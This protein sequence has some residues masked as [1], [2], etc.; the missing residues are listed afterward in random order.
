MP[1]ATPV[2]SAAS[3]SR[4]VRSTSYASTS[5]TAA[6]TLTEI[7]GLPDGI[8]ANPPAIDAVRSIA[9]GYDSANGVL[10]AFDI[11]ADGTSPPRWRREQHHACHPILYPDTGELVTND[12]D[13]DRMMDQIVVLD[14]ETGDERARVDTGSPLQ[15]VVF[16]A[17]GFGRDLYYV[18]FP[19]VSHISVR[20]DRRPRRSRGGRPPD[21][22]SRRAAPSGVST[23]RVIRSARSD[24]E[25]VALRLRGP[26]DELRGRE[27][28]RILGAA[29]AVLEVGEIVGH[30]H[31]SPARRERASAWPSIAARSGAGSCT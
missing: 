10:A 22:R 9:V 20:R 7:C 29:D 16:L 8:V 18:A 12:H 25:P 24:H 30:H 17:P 21:S 11:A 2:P 3:A 31:E 19:M 23:R 28:V 26:R 5:T 27:D 1:R 6:V 4:R 13:G 15:S 14:I